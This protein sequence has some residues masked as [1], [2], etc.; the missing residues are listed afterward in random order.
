M[1]ATSTAHEVPTDDESGGIAGTSEGTAA[2][3]SAAKYAAEVW[4]EASG[5][6]KDTPWRVLI[7]IRRGNVDN[8]CGPPATGKAVIS[9]ERSPSNYLDKY[10]AN[11]MVRA[12]H[13]RN[14]LVDQAQFYWIMQ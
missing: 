3:K 9:A 11:E 1:N 10:D 14:F 12:L 6:R 8:L 2:K 7:S 5:S 13:S 4:A